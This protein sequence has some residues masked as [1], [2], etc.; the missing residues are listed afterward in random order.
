MP[1]N[2][3]LIKFLITS[4]PISTVL[5]FCY[6]IILESFNY[7]ISINYLQLNTDFLDY[8]TQHFQH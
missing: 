1:F 7:Y 5:L 4:G 3:A 2:W 8:L 6:E